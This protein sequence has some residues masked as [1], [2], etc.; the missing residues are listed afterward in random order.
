M[1]VYDLS[2]LLCNSGLSQ[3]F[4]LMGLISIHEKRTIFVSGCSSIR[5]M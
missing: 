1:R 5:E 3:Q 2:V 4:E